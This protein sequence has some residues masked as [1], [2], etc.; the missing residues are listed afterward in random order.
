MDVNKV[1]SKIESIIDSKIILA[2]L[3]GSNSFRR[4]VP[5]SDID[6]VAISSGSINKTLRLN[7]NIDVWAHSYVD[8]C[9]CGVYAFSSCDFV[10]L[11]NILYC[12][13]DS[14]SSFIDKNKEKLF[15]SF[16]PRFYNCFIDE[17][18]FLI[19]LSQE[20]YNDNF[21]FL[22]SKMEVCIKSMFLFHDYMRNR[23]LPTLSDE[24]IQFLRDI[25]G[26]DDTI[27]SYSDCLLTFDSY[28]TDEFLDF[29]S[30]YSYSDD[31]AKD[32]MRRLE[33][34]GGKINEQ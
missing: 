30:K 15:L 27:I 17:I 14:Y 9:D 1:I 28:L 4:T 3:V 11:N 16:I 12:I 29:Y 8:T 31:V 7:H 22:S 32:F 6:I 24:Q 25:R 33:Y 20:H 21:R 2:F 10:S 18:I 23:N 34:I 13:E 26:K 19:S 5:N